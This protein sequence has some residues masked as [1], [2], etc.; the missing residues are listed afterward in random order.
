MEAAG[1]E[2]SGMHKNDG[3][4]NTSKEELDRLIALKPLEYQV[5]FENAMVGI[6]YTIDRKIVR[7][8]RRF[9]ELFGYAPGELDGQ[10]LRV[11][12]RNAEEFEAIGRIGYQL[13]RRRGVYEDE[14]FMVNKDGKK[15]WIKWSGR[16]LDKVDPIKGALW[17]CVD[18]SRRKRAEESLHFAYEELEHKV[19]ER[20]ADLVRTNQALADENERRKRS[21]EIARIQQSELARM[22]RISSMG[23]MAATLAHQ[24]GQP[25][26]SALNYLH[27]C[28]LRIQSGQFDQAAISSA[29]E[30]AIQHTQHAGD[31]IQH[32]RQFVQKYEPAR[33]SV[34]DLNAHLHHCIAFLQFEL[35]RKNVDVELSLQEDLPPIAFDRIEIEQVMLNLIR[36][37]IEA[38]QSMPRDERRI[39]ITSKRR[40]ACVHVSISDSGTGVAAEFRKNIFEPFFTTKNDGIG[41]GL[42]ICRSI[43]EA[44]GGKLT[45][46]RPE[47]RGTTF[48][49]TLPVR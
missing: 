21:E 22:S 11:L 24:M 18:I 1:E 14:R 27:G 12:Y 19:Q 20:T 47:Q 8:N 6:V 40:D 45:L 42:V 7:C 48:T 38:M 23:E 25:L 16:A 5:I 29:I 28:L 2:R 36:N 49:F 30:S 15:L 46:G 31:I 26:S 34:Q 44:H 17:I 3:V 39:R 43:I 10:N 35:N 4:I 9:E 13:I 33:F 41:I 32:V 37:A